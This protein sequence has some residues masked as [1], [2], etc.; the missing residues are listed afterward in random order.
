[1]E[2]LEDAEEKLK[3]A[4]VPFL[5]A[6]FSRFHQQK[7]IW[8]RIISILTEIDC[9][10]SLSI[11]SSCSDIQMV[12]PILIPYEGEYKNKSLLDVKSMVHPCVKMQATKKMFVPND[13]YI[14]SKRLANSGSSS[15]TKNSN[16]SV[17]SSGKEV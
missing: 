1:M 9:L 10:S 11:A 12:R 8:S 14:S 5:C 17:D 4:M 2:C 3:D 16:N 13:T 7:D 6:I 15:I